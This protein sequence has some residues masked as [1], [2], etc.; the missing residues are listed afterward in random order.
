MVAPG[1]TAATEADRAYLQTM[2]LNSTA[3]MEKCSTF[4][5]ILA[6]SI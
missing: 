3:G 5:Q 2:I 1:I 4:S 6:K